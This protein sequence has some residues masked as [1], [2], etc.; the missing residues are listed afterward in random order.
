ML[1]LLLYLLQRQSRR[2]SR[3]LLQQLSMLLQP[4]NALADNVNL[5]SDTEPTMLI[6]VHVKLAL[7]IWM[8][9]KNLT[10]LMLVV[11]RRKNMS[12]THTPDHSRPPTVLSILC[13]LILWPQEMALAIPLR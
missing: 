5:L 10:S 1:S 3:L 11:T 7:W 6:L 13:Q 4:S 2:F 8:L 9:V 12:P